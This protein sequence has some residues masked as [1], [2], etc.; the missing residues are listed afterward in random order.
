[1]L[2]FL[3]QLLQE[4]AEQVKGLSKERAAVEAQRN[5]LVQQLLHASAELAS[6]KIPDLADLQVLVQPTQ[7]EPGS[8]SGVS[9]EGVIP[10]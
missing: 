5:A 9:R 1:M 7:R 8:D 10:Q 2:I 4:A 3:I 6:G